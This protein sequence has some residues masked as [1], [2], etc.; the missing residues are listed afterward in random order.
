L[1]GL[2]AVVGALV[3]VCTADVVCCTPKDDM[4][5]SDLQG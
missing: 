3:H 5:P 4:S 1:P 2:V